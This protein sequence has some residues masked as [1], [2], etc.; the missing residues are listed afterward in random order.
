MNRHV[1]SSTVAIVLSV[2]AL[3]AWTA[4][5][6][7][8]RDPQAVFDKANDAYRD[9]RFNDAIDGYRQLLAAGYRP[10]EVYYNLGNAQFRAGN[11]GKSLANYE[12]ARRLRPRDPNIK[13]N[14]AYARSRARD[15]IK[16]E[17]LPGFV[18][19]TL[20]WYRAVNRTEMNVLMASAYVL[21]WLILAARLIWRRTGLVRAAVATACLCGRLAA[22]AAGKYYEERPGTKGFIVADTTAVRAGHGKKYTQLFDLHDGAEVSVQE[23]SA[24]WYLIE[25]DANKR[26]WVPADS[27]DIL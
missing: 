21:F 25:V 18:A 8:I 7:T 23:S 3:V 14:A 1:L 9:G 19:R 15:S 5:S 11:I 4:G 24:G 17:P 27:I 20:F 12:R 22:S 10:A 26:G 13:A 6:Q 2:C 16:K